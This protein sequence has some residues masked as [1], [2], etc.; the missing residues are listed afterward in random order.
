MTV[1]TVQ[2]LADYGPDRC[3]TLT[4][5]ESRRFCRRLARRRYENF[6]VLTA[7]VPGGLRDDFAALYAFCRWADDLGDEM[8]SP[9]QA[10][11]LLAWW[12]RELTECFAGRPRHPVFVALRPAIERHKLPIE[13]FD[14]LI[15]AF[16]QD[17]TVRRYES[18][19][20]LLSY[21]RL[22]AN[23]VGRLVLMIAGEPRTEELFGLSDAIC[24][25]LQLTNH[26][27]DVRR[28]LRDSDRIYL[29][30][31]LHSIQRFEE[32]L[33]A[34]V[35][36]GFAPDHSFLDESRRLIAAC[37]ERT[38][39]LFE[40]GA[41]LPG[42][43]SPA[44]RPVVWLFLAGGRR[45]LRLVEAWNY[46]T[47]LHRPRLSAAAK[48]FFVSRAW[49]ARSFARSGSWVGAD[50]DATSTGTRRVREAL[51]HCRRITRRR[52]RNF[53][54]GLKL[55]PEPQRSA[56]YALY[57]W[58]R[59]A[60]DLADG[61]P[62][63]AGTAEWRLQKI[64]AFRAAT[65]AALAGEVPDDDPV[66]VALSHTA[67]TFKIRR[68]ALHAMLDGQIEDL[69]IRRYETFREVREYCYRVA[70]TVGLVCIDIWGYADPVA[71]DLAVDRGIAFQ[72]TNILRD[73]KQ[74][75]DAGRVY[76]P[77]EDFARNELVPEDLRRW[78]DPRRCTRLVLEQVERAKSFYDR[79]A[80]LEG[81]ITPS[82]RPTLW[83]MTTIYRSLLAKVERVPGRIV[84][85]R[86]LRLNSLQKGTVAIR[87]RWAGMAQ[88]TGPLRAGSS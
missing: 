16:E 78:S 35:R 77:L 72:L 88:N 44:T 50:G 83:A 51:R 67:A 63:A 61:A 57:A 54:Y 58:M 82:C 86:R 4:V 66:W 39:P 59:R 79:S 33:L 41:P 49:L 48:A 25:A 3:R 24:T 7:L 2:Q 60:D 18:W 20:Q 11:E 12:R 38:W 15:R 71:R 8:E 68:E 10:R 81:L 31:E 85:D 45:V 32:R 62:G 19:E 34:T 70:S 27:Q 65:D 64:E 42:K 13:P 84:A 21:C 14:D 69:K 1:N 36:Q 73:F 40:E 74:D 9:D 5:Q 29:P 53:Y 47:V 87:A 37:V 75:Y 17:Q 76:L 56:I 46:E 22:S 23:P 80:A 26:W 6:S 28:D 30:R 43:L 55:A 52:A